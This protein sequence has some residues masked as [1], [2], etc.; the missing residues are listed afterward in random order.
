MLKSIAKFSFAILLILF[1]ISLIIQM[2]Y[3]IS[4]TEYLAYSMPLTREEQ[5]YL[6]EKGTLFYG[7]DTEA[8]P[9]SFL[10]E[11]T[12]NPAGLVVDYMS[13][14]G[15]EMG[16]DVVCRPVAQAEVVEALRKGEIDMTDLFQDPEGNQ[17]YLSTQSIYQ[18][19]G[20]MVTQYEN[21]EISQYR[22]MQGKRLLL[23]EGDFL[24]PKVLRAFPREQQMDI[25]YVDS[26]KT[27]LTM[28]ME[29]QA[30]AMVANEAVIDE[31]AADMG[32]KSALRQVGGEVY[33]E[34]VTLA[35]DIYETKLYNILNKEI[36]Q[37][38]K[39]QVLSDIQE[40]W[41]GSSAPIVNDSISVKWAQWI[42]VFCVSAVVLLMIWESVLNR[43]I[44]QK[45]REIQ[46]ERNN[47][48]TVID[49]IHALIAVINSDEIIVQCNAYG[50]K[51]LQEKNGACIG[52]GIG[53]VGMLQDLYNL[54]QEDTAA[55]Y[56]SYHGRY[57][58]I[59]VSTVNKNKN[60]RLIQIE[61]NTEKV[62]SEQKLRQESKMIAVGQLSA[63]LA[64]EIRNPLGLIKNYAYILRDFAQEDMADHALN[65]IGDSADRIDHLVENLLHF[66]R[67]SND[68]PALLNIEA[69]LQNIVELER[70]KIEKQQITLSLL[71][72]ENLSLCTREETIKIVAFNLINN[73]V[74]AFTEI[75]RQERKLEIRA[76]L[77]ENVLTLEVEDNGPGMS[78]ET[79]ENVFNPFFSTKDTGTGLG[80]YIVSTEL[81]RVNGQISVKSVQG[82]GS[83]FTV[84]LP[85]ERQKEQ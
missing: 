19:R 4:F 84:L 1:S 29:G 81:A 9:F 74:E 30:D 57:Y 58:S 35:V 27:G 61:D 70:K 28:L 13:F 82:E 2:K 50:E 34:D 77:T 32:I 42:I 14:F 8:A 55:S 33:K 54:Y 79:M 48:Q 20:I 37:L 17:R 85:G 71:C 21:R 38:K 41:L 31:Y 80:L 5:Q 24:A 10:D 62:L 22:D 72:P 59:S 66:S 43:R 76:A 49:H 69:L 3:S 75:E 67:L 39:K 36:L 12:G 63:G 65:V 18:L 26:V 40:R 46:I 56:Y 25:C 47:L 45:T 52:C 23:I 11:K 60:N 44:D 83:V 53:T 68:Q 15:L 78:P 51:M 16:V 73:A 64:H 6:A 7:V